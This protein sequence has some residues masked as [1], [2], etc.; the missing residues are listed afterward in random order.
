MAGSSPF[1]PRNQFSI[2]ILDLLSVRQTTCAPA[3]DWLLL[4]LILS[5]NIITDFLVCAPRLAVPPE[6]WVGQHFVP[7]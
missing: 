2:L 5:E 3:A 6:A 7:D 1:F 4:A